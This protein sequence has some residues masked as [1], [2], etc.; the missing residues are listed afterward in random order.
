V[1]TLHWLW[2]SSVT[3]PSHRAC[4]PRCPSFFYSS[5][6][7]FTTTTLP[8]IKLNPTADTYHR[9][10]IF[11]VLWFRIHNAQQTTK[12]LQ[13]ALWLKVLLRPLARPQLKSV[14]LH[15]PLTQHTLTTLYATFPTPRP[16]YSY[17]F[18][19]NQQWATDK[20]V[21]PNERRKPTD[22]RDKGG[23]WWARLRQRAVTRL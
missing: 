15:L 22:N 21:R 6:F 12:N 20:L 9:S 7:L 8:F 23:P 13:H 18:I 10:H 3:N 14:Y 1:T 4:C 2:C 11:D 17:Q 19:P 16:E 5:Y